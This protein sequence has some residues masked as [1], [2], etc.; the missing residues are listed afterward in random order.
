MMPST[1]RTTLI[2]FSDTV[3]GPEPFSN[4]QERLTQKINALKA[5][6]ETALLDA[7]FAAV[8]TLEAQNP[9]GKKR[10]I[11]AMTDGIDN[12]SRRRVDEV[13][14][15]ARSANIPL[16][17]IGLGREQEIDERTMR[18]MAKETGGDYV[19]ASNEQGPRQ[20]LRGLFVQDS[21]GRHR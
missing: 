2:P 20:I 14:L 1:A 19:R 6:G 11:V 10:R 18:L 3:E 13:V 17:L 21:R 4:D 5:D 8:A 9:D 12:K 15:R 7:I 16:Y